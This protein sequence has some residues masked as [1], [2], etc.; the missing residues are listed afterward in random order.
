MEKLAQEIEEAFKRQIDLQS[1][2]SVLNLA[3][4]EEIRR[5]T[6]SEILEEVF[7]EQINQTL[8]D[9]FF[10]SSFF[11]D[12]NWGEE[13]QTERGSTEEFTDF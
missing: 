12:E 8:E 11:S 6:A 1:E 5:E 9:P 10:R 13:F 2:Q 3:E 4:I 7:W